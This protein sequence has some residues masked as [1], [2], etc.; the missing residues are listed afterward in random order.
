MLGGGA[1]LGFS[2]LM[3]AA[4]LVFLS[5]AMDQQINCAAMIGIVVVTCFAAM[6]AAV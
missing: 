6:A 4:D 1:L 3:L 5:A 2:G